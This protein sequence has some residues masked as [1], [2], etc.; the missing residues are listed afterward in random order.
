MNVVLPELLGY[1][2]TNVGKISLDWVRNEWLWVLSLLYRHPDVFH[3][4][5]SAD[6]PIWGGANEGREVV[7]KS[8]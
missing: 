1:E 4:A 6:A 7:R 8:I 2:A 3:R 5:V